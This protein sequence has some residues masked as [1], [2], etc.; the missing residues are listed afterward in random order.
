MSWQLLSQTK[1]RAAKD[2]RCTWCNEA[3]P[4][5]SIYDKTV[6][7]FEGEFQS[8]QMHLECAEASARLFKEFGEDCYSLGEF[9]RGSTEAR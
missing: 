9:K 2:H 3:I 5:D 4:T 7:I 6:G 1:P 8:S